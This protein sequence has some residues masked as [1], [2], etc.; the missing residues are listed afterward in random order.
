MITGDSVGYHARNTKEAG[1]K[2][3]RAIAAVLALVLV[4][5]GGAQAAG[6]FDNLALSPRARA[7]DRKSVV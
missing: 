3:T 2:G 6:V 7:L 1:V 5:A 4:T